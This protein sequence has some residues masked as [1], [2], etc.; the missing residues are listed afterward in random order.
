[1]YCHFIRYT[2]LRSLSRSSLCA[3]TIDNEEQT[4]F[5]K[6]IRS[7]QRPILSTTPLVNPSN[8]RN[9]PSN[10][11]RSVSWS[12]DNFVPSISGVVLGARPRS[13][14]K[15]WYGKAWMIDVGDEGFGRAFCHSTKQSVAEFEKKMKRTLIILSQTPN[16][17]SN[18][19]NSHSTLPSPL[20][21]L[22]SNSSTNQSG[23]VARRS[24]SSILRRTTKW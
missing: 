9:L 18:L 8:T 16:N 19:P 14:S 1:M 4:E 11:L 5:S 24:I 15:R 3:D 12:V 7:S 20:P 23:N 17:S 6:K 13:E 22:L 21:S 10:S 2:S